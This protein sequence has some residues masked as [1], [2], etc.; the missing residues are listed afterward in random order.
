MQQQPPAF[1]ISPNAV[2]TEQIQKCLEENKNLILAILEYQKL[3]KFQECAQ[4]QA[5]LQR[6][7]MYLAAIADAQPPTPQIPNGPNPSQVMQIA[8]NAIPQQANNLMQQPQPP[9]HATVQQLSVGG[10]KLPFQLNSFRAQDQEQL[11]Q[12]QQQQLFQAQMGLLRPG[13]Q[14]DLFEMQSSMMANRGGPQDGSEMAL[15]GDSRIMQH[16]YGGFRDS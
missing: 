16:N 10:Q 14:N 8:P 13:A 2:T 4:Y 12:F 6:N 11:L 1:K 15:G 3:G 9:Q 5:V 7:L